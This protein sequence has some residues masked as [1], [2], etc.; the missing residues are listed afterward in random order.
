MNANAKQDESRTASETRAKEY[1]ATYRKPMKYRN[2]MKQSE[3]ESLWGPKSE[4]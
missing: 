4:P 1:F 2:E 3:D